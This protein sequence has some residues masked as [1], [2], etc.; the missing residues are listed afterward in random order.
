M[1]VWGGAPSGSPGGRAPGGGS[2]AKLPAADKVFVFK[3]VIFNVSAT[4]M[5]EMMYHVLFELLLL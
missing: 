1:G 3:T 5:H 2:G 4:V